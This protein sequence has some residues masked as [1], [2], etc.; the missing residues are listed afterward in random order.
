M[1]WQDVKDA[2]MMSSGDKMRDFIFMELPH[3]EEGQLFQAN[4]EIMPSQA[5]TLWNCLDLYF[6]I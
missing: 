5:P 1:K 2:K 4:K 3:L 6:N